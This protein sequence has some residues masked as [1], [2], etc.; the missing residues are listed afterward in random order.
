MARFTNQPVLKTLILLLTIY[1]Y[2]GFS[3]I[4]NLFS[5][6]SEKYMGYALTSTGVGVL[7]GPVIGSALFKAIGYRYTFMVF[8]LYLFVNIIHLIIFIPSD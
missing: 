4:T 3:L 7:L 2:L 6:N 1:L 5:E 8:G